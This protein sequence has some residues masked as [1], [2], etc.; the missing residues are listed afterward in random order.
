MYSDDEIDDEDYLQW[1]VTVQNQAWIV[2]SDEEDLD[3]D[4]RFMECLGAVIHSDLPN[5]GVF[6]PL[7]LVFPN[8]L[9]DRIID[10]VAMYCLSDPLQE[11]LVLR[12]ALRQS[13]RSVCRAVDACPLFWSRAIFSPQQGI[14]FQV[15]VLDRVELLDLDFTIRASSTA[16]LDETDVEESLE[17]FMVRM[18]A[19]LHVHF[20]SCTRISVEAMNAVFLDTMLQFLTIISHRSLRTFDVAFPF[21]RYSMFD[22]PVVADF[23]FLTGRSFL[24]TPFTNLSL[25]AASIDRPVATYTS[26]SV[27]SVSIQH[28]RPIFMPWRDIMQVVTASTWLTVLRLDGIRCASIPRDVVSSVPLPQLRELDVRFDGQPSLAAV[29]RVLNAPG[30]LIF[31]FRAASSRDVAC[32][33]ECGAILTSVA[34]FHVITRPN[35]RASMVPVFG[36]LHRTTVLDLRSAS[37]NVFGAFCSASYHDEPF[38]NEAWTCCGRLE[39]LLV[40]GVR[41]S[42]VKWIVEKRID[43]GCASLKRISFEQPAGFARGATFHPDRPRPIPLFRTFGIELSLKFS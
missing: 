11:A 14:S 9:L 17:Q 18:T 27:L 40:R 15:D 4:S 33:L 1:L 36:W 35:F 29:L 7:H 31:K 16:G 41:I 21:G 13:S 10:F 30:L 12:G 39:H 42:R 2:D 20:S 6:M 23:K 32:L 24:F 28:P 25:T 8:F 5:N 43:T 19:L 34:E 37:I 22:P 3:A 38:P 26:S